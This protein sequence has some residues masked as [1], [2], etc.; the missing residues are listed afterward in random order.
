[1]M[2]KKMTIAAMMLMI[3]SVAGAA[4]PIFSDDFSTSALLAEQWKLSPSERWK[5]SDGVLSVSAAGSAYASPM[6]SPVS[7]PVEVTCR[8]KNLG[9]NNKGGWCGI[10]VRGILF[11]LQPAGFWHVYNID[12]QKRASGGIKT[13]NPPVVGRWYDFKI[14][15]QGNSY[16]WFVDGRKVADFIEPNKIKDK[17]STMSLATSGPSIAYDNVSITPLPIDKNSSP[18]LIRNSSFEVVPDHV[19]TYWKPWAISTVPPEIFWKKWRVDDTEAYDGKKSL[20]VEARGGKGCG[21]FSHNNRMAVGEPC[22]YSVYLK[23]DRPKLKAELVYWEFLGNWSKKPIVIGTEWKRYSLT[24]DNPEK[25]QVRCGL[26]IWT[27][28]VAWADAAQIE[29]GTNVTPYRLASLDTKMSAED[30][31]VIT[32]PAVCDLK[33][34]KVAPK[35]DGKLDD[36]VWNDAAKVWPLVST[37][38]DEAVAP[39][40]AYML[41]ADNTLYIGMRCYDDYINDL[42]TDITQHDGMVF[43]DDSVEIFLDTNRDKT[44]YYHLAVN[45]M[46]TRFDTGPGKNLMWNRNWTAKTFIGNK[47]WSV[48][49]AIPLSSMDVTPLISSEWGVNLCR[50]YHKKE[51]FSSTA[52]VP[53]SLNFH[54]PE[55]YSVLKWPAGAFAERMIYPQDLKLLKKSDGTLNLSGSIVNHTGRKLSVTISGEIADTSFEIPNISISNRDNASIGKTLTGEDIKSNEVFVK[56]IIRE[57]ATKN[58]LREY[59]SMLP[60]ISSAENIATVKTDWTDYTAGVVP[61][62]PDRRCIMVDGQPFFV[63]AP[64]L[65]LNSLTTRQNTDLAVNHH[66][67]NGFRSIMVVSKIEQPWCDAAW[68]NIF[69]SCQSRGMK[70]V[71]WPGGFRDVEPEIHEKFIKK[72]RDNPAL[73]AW[74]PVDEPELYA[75]V[76]QTQKMIAL[77]KEA[78]PN[79]PVFMNNT[80]MGIPSRFAG[81]PGDIISID[82]YLT[83]REGRKVKEIVRQV[84]MMNK[85]AIPSHR[86]VWMFI[87]GNNLHNHTREPTAG[88]QVAQTYGC[89]IAGASGLTYFLGGPAGKEDWFAMRKVNREIMDLGPVFLSV[90]SAPAVICSTPDI[91]FTTKRLGSSVYLLAVNLENSAH[92]EVR[93]ELSGLSGGNAVVLFE[94]RMVDIDSGIIADKFGPHERHVYRVEM[95]GE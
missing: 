65:S 1:M 61:V 58:I 13:T 5:I 92:D 74:L 95:M 54:C 69:A 89:A 86:P 62:D 51:E 15:Q 40:D 75:T 84:D 27:D 7:G 21:F 6:I 2:L 55:R 26:R 37:G 3:V 94:D 30:N 72:W 8:V 39:T 77:Y 46:G 85:A 17:A 42:K 29:S 90:E 38:N 16:T 20:R 35:L 71:A 76:E 32:E 53:G 19:P 80:H 34:S 24:L 28:G 41:L 81:L 83:N 18:N 43:S 91:R 36:S 47:F 66:A 31:A 23:A 64:L 56:A 12:G 82:D 87:S 14:I 50:G 11:T 60:V 9:F 67:D 57:A 68:S 49:I 93:F 4:A 22:T 25:M 45:A 59:S 48:E 10:K 63:L 52:I 73:L 79:H 88:E 33:Q 70:I 44:D 78:D